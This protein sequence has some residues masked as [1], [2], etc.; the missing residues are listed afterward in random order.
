MSTAIRRWITV[1]HIFIAQLQGL[2]LVHRILRDDLTRGDMTAAGRD[3][4]IAAELLRASAAAMALAKGIESGEYANEVRPSMQPPNVA[5]GFSGLWSADHAAVLQTMRQVG[6]ILSNTPALGPC[7]DTYL[8][9]LSKVY[10]AHA[11]ICAAFV[12]SGA[13]LQMLVETDATESGADQLRGRLRL[14]TLTYAG[15]EGA[16]DDHGS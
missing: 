4:L 3:L 9:I 11:D 12:G 2:L 16:T 7:R 8:R 15:S 10:V 1:H 6:P 13:S 5:Q 14:R